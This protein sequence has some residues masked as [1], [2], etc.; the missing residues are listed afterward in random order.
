ML[1]PWVGGACAPSRGPWAGAATAPVCPVHTSDCARGT[2][3]FRPHTHGHPLPGPRSVSP[4][5]WAWLCLSAA[6][7]PPRSHQVGVTRDGPG[8]HSLGPCCS[9]GGSVLCT[10]RVQPTPSAC[11]AGDA[12]GPGQADRGAPPCPRRDPDTRGGT[13]GACAKIPWLGTHGPG[14]G[15]LGAGQPCG[16]AHFTSHEERIARGRCRGEQGGEPGWRGWGLGTWGHTWLR[17]SKTKLETPLE[18]LASKST[19]GNPATQQTPYA[20]GLSLCSA[21]LGLVP[22]CLQRKGLAL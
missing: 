17:A 3:H 19:D 12:R 7:R 4:R 9:E 10:R 16:V 21:C 15:R 5:P 13:P 1:G 8:V 14:P 22:S 6:P 20:S 2:S 11:P 18:S